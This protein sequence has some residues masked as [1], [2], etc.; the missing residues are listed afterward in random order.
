MNKES[1][2]DDNLKAIEVLRRHRIDT[3]GS[4]IPGPDY[5]K[6]DWDR[7]WKF[8]NDTGLYYVNISPA[9]PL[10]GA[11]MWDDY[12]DK[13]TVPVDAHGLFDL[14]HMILPT[15]M[16]LKDYYR[17]LLRLYGR[18]ILSLTR[19][20]NNTFR[21]LPSI[22]SLGYF[23]I[24]QGSLKIGRQFMLAHHHHS[25]KEIA[26]AQ[27]KGEPVPGLTF[28]TKLQHPSFKKVEQQLEEKAIA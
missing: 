25:A 11:D 5:E 4:L 16:P 22:W 28:E 23:R 3:Y 21:T 14:S 7:L 13:L 20:K 19:A 24:L 15:K 9:T 27:Y 8:I 10:P 12:K 2:A 17:E 6:K 18:T 1:P 26:L